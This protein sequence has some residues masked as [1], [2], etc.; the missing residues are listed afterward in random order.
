[1]LRLHGFPYYTHQVVIEGF[2]VRLVLQLGGEVFQSLPRVVLPAV[3]API[4]ER[5]HPPAQRVEQGG[6]GQRRG[7]DGYLRF[8]TGERAEGVLHGDNTTKVEESQHRGE[9][10]VDEGTVY[11]EVYVVEAVPQHRDPDGSGQGDE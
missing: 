11:D 7:N 6:Y 2:Q 10:T 5:L 1:M 9:R 8:L 3:E 4:H